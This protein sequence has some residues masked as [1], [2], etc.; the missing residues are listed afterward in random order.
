VRPGR[1]GEH[2]QPSGRART[3]TSSGPAG[4]H[5][6]GPP[7]GRHVDVGD[8]RAL[9]LRRSQRHIVRVTPR[10]PP[11]DVQRHDGRRHCHRVRRDSRRPRRP[12]HG[13]SRYPIVRGRRRS[14]A[15]GPRRDDLGW[16][17]PAWSPRGRC[18]VAQQRWSRVGGTSARS[19]VHS[20]RCHRGQ[21]HRAA[22][23][24]GGGRGQRPADMGPTG[25]S[26][27]RDLG[28]VGRWGGSAQGHVSHS[29]RI[30]RPML[31]PGLLR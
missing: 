21:R 16:T 22:R 29:V 10:G 24:G 15:P 7:G 2:R 11:C 12:E 4:R 9:G 1:I 13:V 23:R 28:A 18:G 31:S 3:R 17:Q 6:G 30:G 25:S 8:R 27:R 26:C 14:F 5:C 19:A 20:A